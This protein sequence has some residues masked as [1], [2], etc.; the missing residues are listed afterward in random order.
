MALSVDVFRQKRLDDMDCTNGGI[1]GKHDDLIVVNCDGPIDLDN[2]NMH[3]AVWLRKGVR[4]S[5]IL[6]PVYPP[7]N[8]VGPMFGGNY[9]TGDSRFSAAVERIAGIY[10]YGAIPIHD[11]F[12]TASEFRSYSL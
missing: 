10:I 3:K 12:E 8:M 4:R 9:A 6:V 11:R 2:D 5:A 7:K 1:S